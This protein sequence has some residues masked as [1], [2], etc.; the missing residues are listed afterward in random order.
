MASGLAWYKV[1]YLPAGKKKTVTREVKAKSGSAAS[2][3]V[4]S[5]VLGATVVSTQY[6]YEV[7]G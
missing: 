2:D 5:K 7:K 3:L 4:E 1:E 6:L